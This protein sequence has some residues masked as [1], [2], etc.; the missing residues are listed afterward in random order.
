MAQPALLPAELDAS[1]E[2]LH[3]ASFGW[4]RSC[5]DGDPDDAAD[6]LQSTYVKVL[7]GNA[8]FEGRSTFK[9][10]LFGVIRFTTLEVRR[11]RARDAAIA[12]LQ[13]PGLAS[14][15]ADAALIDA[16]EGTL[17][18]NALTML[19]ARQQE[20]MH[21]VFYQSMSIAEA[22]DVMEV[23]VG[24]ART[25]YARGKWRLRTLLTRPMGR[26]GSAG[27]LRPN[28]TPETPDD[29]PRSMGDES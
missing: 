1:L 4:A 23:S 8:V 3:E 27:L 24:S 26:E 9:T 5:C 18:R 14:P 7:S 2:A 28:R 19:P 22:A 12:A 17:L 25:H 20:V 13:E 6:V 29:D 15:P 10:W 16:E 21:L 11:K